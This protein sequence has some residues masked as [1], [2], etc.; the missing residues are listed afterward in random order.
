MEVTVN[1]EAFALLPAAHGAYITVQVRRDLFP[2]VKACLGSR[3]SE[4]IAGTLQGLA[5]RIGPVDAPSDGKLEVVMTFSK[6]NL[7]L[8]VNDSEGR[9][10]WYPVSAP[11]KAGTTY[12]ITVWEYEFPGVEFELKSTLRP[13]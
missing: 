9:E 4:V 3:G 7:D 13:N 11:V 8:S 12:Q 2:G 5:H 10:W 1:R 6:G